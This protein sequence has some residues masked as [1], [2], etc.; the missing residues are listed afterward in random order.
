[1]KHYHYLDGS[2]VQYHRQD[3]RDHRHR[4][5]IKFGGNHEG[6]TCG[7]CPCPFEIR[8]VKEEEPVPAGQVA[9]V[10]VGRAQGEAA[11]EPVPVDQELAVVEEEE[12]VP[13]AQELV[14]EEEEGLGLE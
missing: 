8:V 11:G 14:E 4:A 9:V 12:P 7:R 10:L 5:L 3:H 13:V 1:M 2:K 6:E